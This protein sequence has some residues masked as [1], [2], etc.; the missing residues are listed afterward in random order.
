MDALESVWTEPL[1]DLFSVN[2][3][4]DALLYFISKRS[5]YVVVSS[6]DK[7]TL[8]SRRYFLFKQVTRRLFER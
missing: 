6:K 8:H 4:M 3:G 2:C 5:P 1:T 7:V